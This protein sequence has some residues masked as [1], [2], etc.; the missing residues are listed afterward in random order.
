MIAPVLLLLELELE[1]GS[2]DELEFIEKL[3]EDAVV[4]EVVCEGVE[5]DCLIWVLVVVAAATGKAR[6]C[7]VAGSGPQ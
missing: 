7:A 3:V 5:V 6:K 1:F 4:L 2:P